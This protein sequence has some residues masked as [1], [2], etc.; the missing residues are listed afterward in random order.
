MA[1]CFSSSLSSSTT[2]CFFFFSSS[3]SSL[4]SSPFSSLCRLSLGT[5]VEHWTEPSAAAHSQTAL[6]VE[7]MDVSHQGATA[8]AAAAT[9][10]GTL[11]ATTGSASA[12]TGT[13]A[14]IATTLS[15][16]RAA[17]K[18]KPATMP[19]DDETYGM[20]FGPGFDRFG[21]LN[22]QKKVAPPK[23]TYTTTIA[24]AMS[25][26]PPSI[27]KCE[28]AAAAGGENGGAGFPWWFVDSPNA[29]VYCTLFQPIYSFS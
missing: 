8:A 21:R 6:G 29:C 12:P 19:T 22:K 4:F 7:S 17:A 3:S 23:S 2:A 14:T 18:G 10:N 5:E 9:D 27:D 1:D 20:G 24:N 13:T 16:T 28:N 11:A 15:T 26:S 25:T